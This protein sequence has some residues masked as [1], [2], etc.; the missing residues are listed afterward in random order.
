MVQYCKRGRAYL[1][2]LRLFS[3]CLAL[4]PAAAYAQVPAA[5]P[6]SILFD[7]AG[8]D[9]EARLA[10]ATALGAAAN[11]SA[12]A[13]A[14]IASLGRAALDFENEEELRREAARQLARFTAHAD[15]AATPLIE[16]LYQELARGAS[17]ANVYVAADVARALGALGERRS[18]MPLFRLMH[19]RFPTFTRRQAQL[20]LNQLDFSRESRESPADVPR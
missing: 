13:P 15:L 19:S 10:A 1:R 9:L 6:G 8:R 2:A 3:L 18:F 5:D 12:A 17:P 20:A 11:D 4:A 14:A 16:V 7:R